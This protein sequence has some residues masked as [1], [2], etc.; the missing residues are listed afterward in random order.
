MQ[1]KPIRNEQE[2]RAAPRHFSMR[3]KSPNP[4]ASKRRT[5]MRW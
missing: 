2:Y 5:S 3:L 1:L 4:A